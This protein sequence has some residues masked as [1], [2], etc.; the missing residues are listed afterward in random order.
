[1]AGAAGGAGSPAFRGPAPRGTRP[2]P[3]QP[4]PRGGRWQHSPGRA[5]SPG[6]WLGPGGRHDLLA[7]DLPSVHVLSAFAASGNKVLNRELVIN[8]AGE[9]GMGYW[10]SFLRILISGKDETRFYI[11]FPLL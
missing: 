6:G 5:Q 3:P 10:D 4:A 2:A 7:I 8:L 11:F 1:M 9:L